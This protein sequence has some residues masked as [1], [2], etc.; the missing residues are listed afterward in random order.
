MTLTDLESRALE[1]L[2]HGDS[3]I[4]APLRA[5]MNTCVVT[6]RTF[7]G[8]GFFTDFAVASAAVCRAAAGSFRV[9]DVYAQISGLDHDA[10]FLLLVQRGVLHSLE[11][12]TH[13][14]P[15]PSEPRLIRTYY[16][17]PD[18][19]AGASLVESEVRDLTWALGGGINL[20]P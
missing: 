1:M 14:E 10:G 2:L 11:C 13:G 17:K 16:V 8:A 4:L 12:F 18:G 19:P 5:Q 3:S 6:G 9:G 7:T 20:K 15:W